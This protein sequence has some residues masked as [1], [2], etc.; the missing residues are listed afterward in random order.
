MLRAILVAAASSVALAA[1]LGAGASAHRSGATSARVPSGT[2]SAAEDPGTVTLRVRYSRGPW[3]QLLSLK[4][5]KTKLTSFLVCAIRNY[6]ASKPYDCDLDRGARLPTGMTL[7]LEQ[8]PIAKALN[9]DDSPGWGMLGT[10]TTAR[11]GAVLSNTVTGNKFGTF[12]YRVTLRDD[13]GKV[14]ATSNRISV[15]WHR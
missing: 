4:L 13:S 7:R 10:S 5:V 3:R 15:R 12:R 14:L 2:G 9:R 6:E 11:L 1:P 8:N